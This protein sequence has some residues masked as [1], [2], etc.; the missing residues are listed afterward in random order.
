MRELPCSDLHEKRD[1]LSDAEKLLQKI[2]TGPLVAIHSSLELEPRVKM[3]TLRLH[4]QSMVLAASSSGKKLETKTIADIVGEMRKYAAESP[5]GVGRLSDSLVQLSRDLQDQLNQVK[6]PTDKIKLSE[7]IQVLLEQLVAVSV[8]VNILEW[9]GTT[10]NTLAQGMEETAATQAQAIQLTKGAV[11]AF[12]K[13]MDL[14]SKTPGTIKDAGRKIEDIQTKFGQALRGQGE[15]QAAIDKLEE[16]LATNSKSLM[17]QFEAAKTY[18]IWGQT[19]KSAEYY[20]K[21][22]EGNK[23]SIWGW[24]LLSK[25]LTKAPNLLEYFFEARYHLADCRYNLG[26]LENDAAKKKKIL[27]A[28]VGDLRSTAIQFPKVKE[29]SWF[30]SMDQL[31]RNLQRDLGKPQIGMQEFFAEQAK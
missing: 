28:A 16:A 25:N 30:N 17:P 14:E 8:D 23:K 10:L 13:L 3:E 24:G 7:G 18:Q 11:R 20:K 2:D 21:A 5:E 9:S 4:L 22:I 29:S 12:T 1:R 27:E 6:N 26:L 19:T 15:F 31:M